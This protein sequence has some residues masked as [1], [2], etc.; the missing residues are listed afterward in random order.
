MPRAGNSG[1]VWPMSG[2]IL[3]TNARLIDGT[4]TEPRLGWELLIEN[5]RICRSAPSGTVVAEMTPD[6]ERLRVID[7][8]GATVLPGFIDAHTHMTTV[9]GGDKLEM[10]TAPTSL[11]TLR[12]VPFLR[13]TL[14][15][16]VTTVRDLSGADA[17]MKMALEEGSIEGPRVQVALRIL[18]ITGGHGDWRTIGGTDLTGGSD[19]G[20]IAD[21]VDGFVRATREVVREGADWIKIAA[22]GGM[23]SPRSSPEYGGLSFDEIKAVVGEA[24]RHGVA[25]VAAHAQGRRGISDAVRA[26]VR[27]V[28]HGY[29]IDDRTIE[30]MGSRGTYLVP[31]L[32]TLTRPIPV[33]SMSPE[34]VLVRRE[35]NDRA[36]ERLQ[37]AISS[38]IEVVLGTDAGI[39]GHG[40]NLRELALLVE[41]GLSPMDAILAGTSRAARMCGL[42]HLVGTIAEGMVADLVVSVSDPLEDP[43]CLAESGGISLVMQ[44]GIVVGE[45]ICHGRLK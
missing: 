28:E 9:P 4:G 11:K 27:S 18:S 29:W 26:G 15:A 5:G 32:A 34:A 17:G 25:G 42:D 1:K 8:A 38:G 44:S 39:V 41:Y 6:P 43:S 3:L 19:G 40:Q 20:A 22:S 30:E 36:Q 13:N 10:L 24:E 23:G 21:G 37:V 12:A 7:L 45:H 35:W 16:G 33:D 2:S 14:A 31:T